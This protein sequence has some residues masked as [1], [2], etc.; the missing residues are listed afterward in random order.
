MAIHADAYL[1]NALNTPRPES[2]VQLG[3][4]Q[5]KAIR[6]LAN[7]FDAKT[8]IPKRNALPTPHTC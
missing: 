5:L 6:E 7:I 3:D 2:P 8:K 4:A 1:A